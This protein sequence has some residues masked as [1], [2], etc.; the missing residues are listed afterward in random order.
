VAATDII[1][2]TDNSLREPIFSLCLNQVKSA[3]Q[4]RRIICVSHRP[5]ALGD[6]ICVG[7]IGR[8]YQSY[9]VQILAG[10]KAAT[11]EYVAT[12]E[13]D[14]LYAPG[15]FEFTPPSDNIFYYNSNVWFAA[16]AT[17]VYS[18]YRRKIQS[19]MI[20]NRKLLIGAIEEKLAQVLSDYPSEGKAKYQ[21]EPGVCDHRPEFIEAKMNWCNKQS[22]PFKQYR[23]EFFGS[24]MPNLDIRHDGNFT[25]PGSYRA[26]KHFTR[27]LPYWGNFHE[28]CNISN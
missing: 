19:N 1:Y 12:V 9:Y 16:Y 3:A 26:A 21:C 6:N 4:G 15:Y 20:C 28:Y 13:H 24:H 14:C 27:E 8:S 5:T 23:S 22:R 25:R 7:D 18:Y 2:Y 17:G 10:A 11:T